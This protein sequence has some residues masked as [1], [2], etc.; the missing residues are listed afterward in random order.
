MASPAIADVIRRKVLPLVLWLGLVAAAFF[1]WR[2]MGAGQAVRGFA[3]AIPFRLASL[4]PARVEAVLVRL[5][6]HVSAGQVV[7]VLDARALDGELR[8]AEAE[9]ARVLGEIAKARIEAR[10]GRTEALRGIANSRS[11]VERAL[12]E[13]RTRRETARAE[14]GALK[15]E[16][17]RQR[18]AVAAGLMRAAEIAELEI[19]LAAL[20]KLAAEE[21]AAVAI[22]ERQV[23]EMGELETTGELAWIEAA[24]AP[25]E[26]ELEVWEGQARAL[27][28]RRDQHILR[29]PAD[30]QVSAVHGARDATVTPELPLVEIVAHAPGRIVACVSEDVPVA[31][32]VGLA[33]RVRPLSAWDR[34]LEGRTVSVGPVIE[35]PLRCW[36]D[37]RQPLWGR[38]VTVE[39]GPGESIVPGESLEV[40][41]EPDGG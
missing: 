28:A 35:L 20:T 13:A 41:F 15:R 22:Y 2:S 29:A 6:D 4:E 32:G 11:E 30:G 5:G 24:I 21:D 14:L 1:T 23:A 38:L 16:L 37:A 36:R 8:A 31:V 33:A 27:M 17:G 40:R 26:A 34:E 12:R 39:L 10:A 9:K 3:E 19:R 7:A 18:E 25:L